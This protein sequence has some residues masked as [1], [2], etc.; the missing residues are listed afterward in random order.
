[1][2]QRIRPPCFC[3]SPTVT[4]LIIYIKCYIYGISPLPF[5]LSQLCLSGHFSILYYHKWFI[6]NSSLHNFN[7]EISLIQTL[8][9]LR[10]NYY[11]SVDFKI[12][13]YTI[14]FKK[15]FCHKYEI[16]NVF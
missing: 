6:T 4:L 15:W 7:S 10:R 3:L 13:Y 11:A 16:W 1:M 5:S 12:K 8:A 14:Y 2:Q 9:F